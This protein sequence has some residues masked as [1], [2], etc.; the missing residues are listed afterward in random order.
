[1]SKP[2]IKDLLKSKNI[3]TLPIFTEDYLV[4]T[5]LTQTKNLNNFGNEVSSD[6]Y[7]DSYDSLKFLNYIHYLNFKN[8]ISVDNNIVN[9]IPYT[10]VIDNFR[11]DYDDQQ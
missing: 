2:F 6:L 4:N 7:D 10:Q 9:P 11:A 8:I 1:V 3:Y 5:L